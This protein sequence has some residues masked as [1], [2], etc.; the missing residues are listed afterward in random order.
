MN[1]YEVITLLLVSKCILYIR[2]GIV[3][4]IHKVDDNKLKITKTKKNSNSNYKI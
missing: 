1:S 4:D 3:I 2:L